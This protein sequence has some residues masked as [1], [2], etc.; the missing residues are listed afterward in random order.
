MKNAKRLLA[1]LLVLVLALM[2]FA[3]GGGKTP[4]D[5]CSDTDGDKKC[6]ACGKDM[7]AD[8]KED[9]LLFDG[10][11]PTFQ[12]VIANDIASTMRQIVNTNVKIMLQKEY[13]VTVDV[14]VEG[15]A[16][17]VEIE[18][19]VLIGTVKS[20]GDKYALDGHDYGKEGYAIDI[21]GSKIVIVGGCEESLITAVHEFADE[22]LNVGDITDLT[23]MADEVI[24]N[25]IDDYSVTALKI[26]GKDIRGKTLAADLTRDYY[27]NVALE[28]QT[29]FYERIG[30]W[31]E[32]V[33]IG[34]ADDSAIVIKHNSSLPNNES[35][36]AGVI[37]EQFVIECS[38]DNMLERVTPEFA[39]L[40]I[41][42]YEG[43]LELSEISY[44]RDISTVTYEYF[45]AMG[46]GRTDDFKAIYDTHVFA[47]ISGQ[48]VLGNPDATYYIHNTRLLV[49]PSDETETVV[50]VPIGTDTD[51]RGAKF[52][53]DDTDLSTMTGG[54][55]KDMANGNIFTVIPA[56]GQEGELILDE[57]ILAEVSAIG[58]GPGTTKIDLGLGSEALIIPYCSSHKV[59]RRRGYGQF[60]GSVQHEIIVLDAEGNVREETP[61]M[62]NYTDVDKL[63]IYR[64][65][66]TKH[67]TVENGNFITWDT[68][69]NQRVDGEFK[70]TYIYRGLNVQRSYTTVQNIT[71]KV[72]KGFTF[73]DRV[74]GY[75][76]NTTRGIL[77]AN[78]ATNVTFKDC[79]IPARMS[80]GGHSTYNIYGNCVNKLV[81]DN[82][83]QSNFW[84]TIDPSTLEIKEATVIDPDAVGG[85]RKASADAVTGINNY[86]LDGDPNNKDASN[87][88][89]VYYGFCGS[90][91]CKNLEYLNSTFSRLDAHAGLYNGKVINTNIAD[92]ELTGHG[93]FEFRDSAF[94]H[95]YVVGSPSPF[96]YL[97]ADYGYT[98]DGLIEV[99]NVNAY[100]IDEVESIELVRN[101]YTNWYF[102]YTCA[103]PSLIIDNLDFYSVSTGEKK[104]AYTASLTSFSGPL[105]HLLESDTEVWIGVVDENKNGTIDEPLYDRNRD[106]IVDERDL[107]D[108]DGNGVMGETS[109]EYEDYRYNEDGTE[110]EKGIKLDVRVNVNIVKPPE[111]I[112]VVNLDEGYKIRIYDTA[113]AG[114]SDGAW[115]DDNETFGGFFGDTKFYYGTGDED[116]FVGTASKNETGSMEFKK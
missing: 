5:V 90:N 89:R 28:L 46:D 7:P 64:F 87:S 48:K 27:E 92:L 106:N 116:Y 61:I 72:E 13:G 103:F 85:A 77:T 93:Y 40:S 12:I 97:R 79:V 74:N 80:Y 51:W 71:H 25:K 111:F 19:E 52:I 55:N 11:D 110:N 94:Y 78:N 114:I 67:L 23:L 65:D 69:I 109:F 113:G 60:A 14:I 43:E 107:I 44:K 37:G 30:Y 98:W 34:N 33:D 63:A 58:I 91:F 39:A 18:T 66:S 24:I 16:N 57:A 83:I 82:C 26:G 9:V 115:Y 95:S 81:F 112:K 56:P 3:C 88:Y 70:G 49:D 68:K 108:L 76:G 75:D 59:F 53:I 10:E 105:K 99:K 102:G 29:E 104:S 20:R 101:T 96:L 45:D 84:I 62:F 2:L 100:V 86:F 50:S 6:D 38:F 35:Y 42:D 41:Y 21:V 1:L 22:I 32:I 31:F 17:D 8:E 36:R 73:M 54:L 4:C 15:S 47:N